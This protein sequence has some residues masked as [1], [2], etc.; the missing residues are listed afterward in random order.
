MVKENKKVLVELHHPHHFI[1]KKR[2]ELCQ[3]I[4]GGSVL[5]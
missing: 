5:F 4:S 2:T 3:L 1:K